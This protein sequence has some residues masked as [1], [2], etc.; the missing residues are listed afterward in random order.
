MEVS[1]AYHLLECYLAVSVQFQYFQVTDLEQAYGQYKLGDFFSLLS[2]YIL[3][4][5]K[6]TFLAS[7]SSDELLGS[8]SLQPLHGSGAAMLSVT[9]VGSSGYK[10]R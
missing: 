8:S 7:G 6:H 3:Q 5:S 9:A 1:I 4:H 10:P 2:F